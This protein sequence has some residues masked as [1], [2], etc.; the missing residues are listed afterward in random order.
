M[1][2]KKSKN[3]YGELPK[4][5]SEWDIKSISV[6]RLREALFFLMKMKETYTTS[7]DFSYYMTAY[8]MIARSV[9]WILRSEFGHNEGFTEWFASQKSVSKVDSLLKKI[10]KLRN[11]ISKVKPLELSI[12][13][14]VTF[15]KEDIHGLEDIMNKSSEEI[16]AY[17][18]ENL[19]NQNLVLKILNGSDTGKFIPV[20]SVKPKSLEI[21]EI[22]HELFT[23]VMGECELYFGVLWV[24][25][26]QCLLKYHKRLKQAGLTVVLKE[27]EKV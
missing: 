23:D 8:I 1:T 2:D 14:S 7:T 21:E 16:T 4:L 27:I 9:S 3:V 25:T 12:K 6:D 11:D 15:N 20:I 18:N 19:A 17:L 24:M 5:L 10:T 26:L 13:G 22:E